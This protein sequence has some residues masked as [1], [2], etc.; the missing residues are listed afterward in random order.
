MNLISW[1]SMLNCF[2]SD[3]SSS[4]LAKVR[5]E[6][7]F[8]GT[9]TPNQST[10]KAQFEFN[11]KIPFDLIENS[12][13]EFIRINKKIFRNFSNKYKIIIKKA[14]QSEIDANDEM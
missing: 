3:E 1:Q 12:E 4:R 9:P 11:K 5:N 14:E 13:S 10:S 8:K 2:T 6:I 7:S